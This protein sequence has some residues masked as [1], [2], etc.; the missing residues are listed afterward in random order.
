MIENQILNDKNQKLLM[1]NGTTSG[2]FVNKSDT[3]EIINITDTENES[4]SS[5]QKSKSTN[6]VSSN[7]NN[8]K[9]SDILAAAAV[10]TSSNQSELPNSVSPTLQELVNKLCLHRRCL[11]DNIIQVNSQAMTSQIGIF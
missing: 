2:H 6:Q 11:Y 3:E 9:K 7:N 4:N 1:S 5:H 10:A 8:N